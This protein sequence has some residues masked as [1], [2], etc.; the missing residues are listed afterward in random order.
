M[1]DASTDPF[2]FTTAGHADL[3]VLGPVPDA[4]VATWVE[5]IAIAHG[6]HPA[7]VLD[8][9]CG[10]G[11]WAVRMLARLPGEGLG[12]E[13]NPSFAHDAR[14]R[15][16]AALGPDRLSIET[17]RWSDAPLAH[18]PFT[19]AVCTGSL[20]AFGRLEEALSTLRTILVPHGLVLLGV[21]YWRQP[22]APGFLEALGASVDDH[23]SSPETLAVIRAHGYDVLDH[24]ES[25]VEACDAYE[26]AYANGIRSWC[27]AHPE[28]PER[29]A[30]ERRIT[31]WSDL[32]DRWARDTLGYVLVLA[33]AIPTTT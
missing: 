5:R 27:A 19:L 1:S 23:T 26:R 16:R 3:R 9:G 17:R 25:S 2:R 29:A 21:P 11:E 33:R 12:I 18:A 10:K 7:R 6:P 28:D 8:V 24:E 15:A 14:E 13:P 32:V 31:R 20:H 22:P 30:F 4:V